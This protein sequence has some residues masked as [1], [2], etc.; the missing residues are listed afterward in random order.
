MSK[1]FFNMLAVFA[2]FEADLDGRPLLREVS[3]RVGQGAKAALVGPNGGG[4]TTLLRLIAGELVLSAGK[5]ANT[6]GLGV[7]RQFT[8]EDRTVRQLLLSVAPPRIKSAT[9]ALARAEAARQGSR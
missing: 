1:M 4:K 8:P 9:D 3:F 6:G 5:V 7:M 2:E